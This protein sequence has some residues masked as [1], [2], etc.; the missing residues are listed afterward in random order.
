MTMQRSLVVLSIIAALAGGPVYAQ[1]IGGNASLSIGT[2]TATVALPSANQTQFPSVILVPSPGTT[3]EIFYALGSASVT[4]SLTSAA[5]PAGGICINTG[6]ATNVA[7]IVAAG[8]ATLRITQVSGCT[9]FSGASAAAGGGSVT[10]TV[11]ANQGTAGASPWPVTAGSNTMTPS[12]NTITPNASAYVAANCL[13]TLWTVTSA[14]RAG[15]SSGHVESM[16]VADTSGQDAAIDAIIFTASPTHST[17]TDHAACAVNASDLGLVAGVV[18]ITD[19]VTLGTPGVTQA[20]QQGLPF[21][22]LTSQTLYVQ[23]V[24]RGTPTYGATQTLTEALHI[25]SD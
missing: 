22:G 4:A 24:V 12:A 10:G 2:S 8:S 21:S 18:H 14:V 23:L 20:Q 1:A 25:N 13:G 17:F 9:T 16:T 6:P 15:A 3:Q 5:L 11:T 19:A 7:A